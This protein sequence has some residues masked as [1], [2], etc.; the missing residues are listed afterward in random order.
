MHVLIDSNVILDWIQ[1]RS[2]FYDSALSIMKLCIF[3]KLNGYVTSHSLCDIFYILR[4]D[5]ETEKR[6]NLIRLLAERFVVIPEIDFETVSANP[7]TRDLEDSLQM[8]CA[9]NYELNYIVTRNIKDF[10]T[11]AVKPILPDEFLELTKNS[12]D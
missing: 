4:K 1:K 2:D 9:K 6:L 7:E 8:I 11:S 5:L 12:K 3:G 10:E